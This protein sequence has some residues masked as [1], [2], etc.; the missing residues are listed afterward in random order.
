[1]LAV[2][3]ETTTGLRNAGSG[4]RMEELHQSYRL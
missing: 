3:I 1:M 2:N 4:R